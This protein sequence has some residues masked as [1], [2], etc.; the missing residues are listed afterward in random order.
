MKNYSYICA[1]KI[2]AHMRRTVLLISFILLSLSMLAQKEVV[3]G[4]VTDQRTGEELTQASITVVGEGVSVVTNDDGYFTL[5]TNKKPET[6]IVSHLGYETKQVKVGNNNQLKIRLKPTTIQL[7]ELVVWTENPR[8]LV[9]IAIS[10]ISDNY[11]K[12]AELYNCFY[13]ETAMKRQHFIYIAEGVTDMYKTAYSH[14]TGR[15]RVA[16][17]KGRRLLSRKQGDTLT[18]KVMGGPAQ[19][20]LL[21]V[22]KNTDFLLNKEELDNYEL[23]MDVPNQIG[24]R[25]QYVINLRPRVVQEYALYYGKL[26]IDRETLAFTRVELSLDMSDR[27]KATRLMLMRKP[28]GVRFKPKEMTSVVDYRFEDGV[29]RLSYIRNVF[30]FNC[31]WKRRL[32]STSFTATCEMVV[33]DKS[34]TD[35]R[36]ISGR[37]SF[38][39][40]DVFYDRVEYFRDPDFW[41]DYNIIEPTETLDN[42]I[43]KLLK[44]Y[45]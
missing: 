35:T 11:S 22:V 40:K 27:E 43:D 32:L 21:D 44:K 37:D 10:K 16:I 19:P 5:K 9:N 1:T 33:T 29:T 26:Y 4:T 14:G 41:K 34:P 23:T 12:E 30:R 20:L 31:D 2:Y 17:R 8:E 3:S 28:L 6:I 42:A 39:S 18:V 45:N 15:D 13:R 7:H 38:D 24:D 25:L 36:P